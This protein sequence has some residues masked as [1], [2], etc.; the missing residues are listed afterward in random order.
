MHEARVL[1]AVKQLGQLR[2]LDR[3]PDHP[4]RDHLD[5]NHDNN[6]GVEQFLHGV[7]VPNVIML[8]P[9]MDRVAQVGNNR[10]WPDRQKFAAKPTG[11]KSVAE[12]KQAIEHQ[13]PHGKEMP[14]QSVLGPD[15]DH[16]PFGKMQPAEQNFV[17]VD[18][19][20]AAD[21]N[22]YRYRIDPMHDAQRER[23]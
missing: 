12:I 3:L 14:L 1:K 6:A 16:H 4:A 21:Q 8:E 18:F 19:P 11:E 2:K 23:M 22:D 10:A 5:D 7:V 9:E 15:S 13:K 20:A 17:V